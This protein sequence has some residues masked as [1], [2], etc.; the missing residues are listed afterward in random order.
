MK[1]KNVVIAGL[2]FAVAVS[3]AFAQMK[4]D[5]AI[6]VRQAGYRFMGWNMS[7]IDASLKG[8]FKKEDVV[9]AAA[10]IQ[11]IA[12]AGLSPLFPAG[13]DKGTGFHETH[14]KSEFF[15]PA[16]SKKVA[17]L[18]G[19]LAK[20]SGELAKVAATGD[21]EAVKVQYGKLG[22]T[23]KACHDDFRKSDH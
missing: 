6:K 18:F 10:A 4:A 11:A 12:N 5:D 22:Q 7:R 15:D 23:C 13:S 17:E 8:E 20:E 1:L 14:L 19:N 21:K 3:S 2:T 9:K 16:N